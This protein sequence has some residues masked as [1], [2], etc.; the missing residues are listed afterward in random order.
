MKIAIL[1][2]IHSNVYA[3]EEVIKDAKNKNVD[4]I[5]NLG[6]SFYGPIAPR[7]T[8]DL[9]KQNNII[10]ICGNQDREILEASLDQLEKNKTL[11]LVYDDLGEEVLYWIQSLPFEKFIHE[12][13]YIVHGTKDDDTVYM[14]EDIKSGKPV[15]KDDKKILELIDDVE[16]KFIICG[17]SHTARC[18]NLSSGQ[19][20]IN[21]GSVGLQAYKDE[22]P[23]EH[24]IEN[25]F[26]DATYIILELQDDSY[27]IELI[28]VSY[29][30]EKAAKDAEKNGRED[31]AYAIRNG[32]V[33][34]S[35]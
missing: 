22:L 1:S 2:D 32:K 11:K 26:S 23:F 24:K 14:L 20:V 33:F 27:N 5:L 30:Y 29:D 8:Y 13:I 12:E 19:V 6:D 17:H 18:V 7:A 4:V 31:W 9:I 3:L 34:T 16:S 25:D 35:L 15:L 10:S 28:N 21:P